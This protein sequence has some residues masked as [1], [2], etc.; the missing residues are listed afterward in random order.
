MS[1]MTA[2]DRRAHLFWT[3]PEGTP[4]Q[5]M[6]DH[7]AAFCENPSILNFSIGLHDYEASEVSW[8]DKQGAFTCSVF[9]VRANN[10]P[11]TLSATEGI[12]SLE[13]QDDTNLGE[14]MVFAYYPDLEVSIVLYN[15]DGPRHSTIRSILNQVGHD[16]P[17]IMSPV[18]REDMMQRLDDA[19]I[20][21]SIEHSLQSPTHRQELQAAGSSVGYALSMLGDVN[22]VNIN[23]K[24]TMGQERG[25]LADT[26]KSTAMKLAEYDDTDLGTLKVKA[27]SDEE[28]TAETLDL[29]NARIVREFSVRANGREMDRTHCGSQLRSLFASVRSIIESQ[30]KAGSNGDG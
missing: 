18:L 6:R 4:P 11:P 17:V 15:H 29:L 16:G 1:E 10:L 24:I 5:E 19:K 27:A 28:S 26:V 7:L 20:F 12:K 14:P 13:I 8:N 22:G 30:R 25:S 21:R 3:Q 2:D 9:R 23:V